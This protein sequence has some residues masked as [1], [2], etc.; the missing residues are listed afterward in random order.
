MSD[1]TEQATPK[2]LIKAR[3]EGDSPISAALSQSVGFIAALSVMGGVVA[4]CTEQTG[5]L[6]ARALQHPNEPASPTTI[7]RVVLGI[8]LPV[9]AVA[10]AASSAA[11]LVQTGANVS[12]KKLTPSLDRLNPITGLRNLFSWQRLVGIGRALLA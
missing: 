9:V 7:A 11:T 1:K 6:L 5:A 12:A 3:T 8:S 10:A 4:L 2:R